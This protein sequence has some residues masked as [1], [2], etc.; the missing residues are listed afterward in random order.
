MTMHI[1]NFLTGLFL[2]NSIPHLVVGVMD[3]RFLSLFG[4]GGKANIAYSVWNV[5]L[6]G[7]IA[8]YA[9]GLDALLYNFFFWG[10]FFIYISYV[11]AGRFLYLKWKTQ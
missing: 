11:A 9:H 5:C 10:V 1:L 7:S 2:A 8:I 6:A 3:I 4:F